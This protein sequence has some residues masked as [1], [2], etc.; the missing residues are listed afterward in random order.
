M[1]EVGKIG[2]GLS[3]RT[4]MKTLGE[5]LV[6]APHYMTVEITPTN[7]LIFSSLLLA[8]RSAARTMSGMKDNGVISGRAIADLA[9]LDDEL[10][11]YRFT[12][13]VTAFDVDI[14]SLDEHPWRNKN[15]DILDY[16]NYGFNERTWMV[17]QTTDR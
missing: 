8:N 12:R 9:A 6:I 7:E 3:R 14:T 5:H 10:K 15:V 4:P 11:K 1:V 2:L 13:H 16:F 17:R